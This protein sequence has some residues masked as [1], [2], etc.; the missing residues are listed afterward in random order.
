MKT[1]K[2]TLILVVLIFTMSGCGPG[3]FFGPTITPT[4]TI[5]PTPTLTPTPTATP[6]PP[7]S[8]DAG[9]SQN[10]AFETLIENGTWV[11]KN[12]KGEITATWDIQSN[13]WF[14][15][16]DAITIN[17]IIAGYMADEPEVYKELLDRPLPPDNLSKHFINPD[18]NEP[19]GYGPWKL[20]MQTMNMLISPG[21]Y[22][23]WDLNFTYVSVQIRGFVKV[24][25]N[26]EIYPVVL[27]SIPSGIDQDNVLALP[28]SNRYEGL[29]RKIERTFASV[30]ISNTDLFSSDFN[31]FYH[32]GEW[33][34][35]DTADNL[36]NNQYF[37]QQVIIIVYG[38]YPLDFASM[39]WPEDEM[40][41]L[42]KTNTE[43]LTFLNGGDQKPKI[44]F[45]NFLQQQ[46]VE[47]FIIFPQEVTGPI[48]IQ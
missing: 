36:F 48:Q 27:F 16:M 20:G 18:S 22:K 13:S 30:G 40:R 33:I 31:F 11:T 32:T 2:S 47:M 42:N 25:R 12:E 6:I 19:L 5:T 28:Y 14:Y 37:G 23:D 4:S 9:L 44:N 43:L 21:H 34:K 45:D 17:Q 46:S 8:V 38:D 26:G 39:F 41:Q 35:E 29:S 15:N 10:N 1:K 7:P 3:E 24:S